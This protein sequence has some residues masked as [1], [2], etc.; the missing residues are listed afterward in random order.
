MR[1]VHVHPDEDAELVERPAEPTNSL[2]S[3]QESPIVGRR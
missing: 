1:Y 3:H 2:I